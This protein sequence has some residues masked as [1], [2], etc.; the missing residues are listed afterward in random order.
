MNDEHYTALARQWF[1]EP[2]RFVIGVAHEEQL[3]LGQTAE[4]ALVGRSNVGKSSLLN[5]LTGVKGLAK[6]SATPGRTQQINFFSVADKFYLADLPGYGYA[7]APQGKVADWTDLIG[8]YLQGRRQLKRVLL[9]LDA[10]HEVKKNDDE[11]MSFLDKTAVV[12]QLVLTKADK[13][14]PEQLHALQEALNP[15]MQ[16]HTA[17]FPQVLITSAQNNTG[18]TEVRRA[19]VQVVKELS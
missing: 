18:I 5:A 6:V 17:C 4:I 8:R 11:M 7:K 16:R 13:V 10:R 14:S 15:V 1:K 9:L 12:Y 3:P 2:A 19:L